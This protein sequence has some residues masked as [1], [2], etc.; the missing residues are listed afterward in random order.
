MQKSVKIPKGQEEKVFQ[1]LKEKGFKERD[2]PNALWS[3]CNKEVCIT[4]YP[5]NTLLLQGKELESWE[6]FI[7]SLIDIPQEVEI[8]CD[9]A[10]KGDIFGPLVLC[11]AVIEPSNYLEV[12][13][14]APKDSKALRDEEL[15]KKVE[16]LSK[17]VKRKC[18]SLEPERLNE[19]HRELKNLNRVLDKAYAKLLEEMRKSYKGR[20]FVDAYSHR[21]PF[22]PD[23][24][25]EPKGERYLSVAVASMFA[26][27]KFLMWLKERDL[28]KGSSKDAISLAKKLLK[29]NPEEAKRLLKLFFLDGERL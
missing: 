29:E 8:G 24:V 11:C 6:S 23:V 25:F 28:P 4:L 22:G 17:V 5:S 10:G 16:K 21:S 14:V 9:E 27:A 20:V 13:S 7:L 26:R 15:L 12:L 3:L 19:L 18:M 2:I 1:S